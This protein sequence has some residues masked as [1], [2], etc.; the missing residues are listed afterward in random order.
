M[1]D[2]VPA[3]AVADG[4]VGLRVGRTFANA[5]ASDTVTST[6]RRLRFRKSSYG[7]GG[8]SSFWHAAGDDQLD[9]SV[10]VVMAAIL[11]ASACDPSAFFVVDIG[12]GTSGAWY[13]L[14][15]TTLGYN[16]T[17][18]GMQPECNRRTRCGAVMNRV[19]HRLEMHTTY[20]A[21]ASTATVDGASLLTTG[22][23]AV[24]GA[25][26]FEDDVAALQEADQG[27]RDLILP[28]H[29]G[30]YIRHKHRQLNSMGSSSK[31]SSGASVALLRVDRTYPGGEVAAL[32]SLIEADALALIANLLVAVDPSSWGAAGA[33]KEAVVGL[34]PELF[35]AGFTAVAL[36]DGGGNLSA[37]SGVISQTIF[38]DTT[39]LAAYFAHLPAAAAVR[40]PSSRR[41]P[42]STS[43]TRTQARAAI[44]FHVQRRLISSTT[45]EL[46]HSAADDDTI[47][48]AGAGSAAPPHDELQRPSSAWLWF[49]RSKICVD[50]EHTSVT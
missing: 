46:G 18:V 24:S 22:A 42:I 33:S 48:T 4:T 31:S 26:C 39:S 30:R 32:R 9:P 23:K 44:P 45:A 20:V 49:S 13:S 3:D 41:P 40:V 27:Y 6:C 12:H 2:A 37:A 19:T 29:I 47:V 36:S 17:A 38:T 10:A 8:N 43:Q 7:A 21:A 34:L 1:I 28:L 14:M 16:V 25:R 50:V 15:A 11:N 35:K 5:Y